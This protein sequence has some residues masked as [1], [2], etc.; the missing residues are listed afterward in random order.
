MVK[1]SAKGFEILC[2]QVNE[3]SL[4]M[5]KLCKNYLSLQRIFKLILKIIINY[6]FDVMSMS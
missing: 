5:C 2:M 4:K 3:L 1:K 6:Q